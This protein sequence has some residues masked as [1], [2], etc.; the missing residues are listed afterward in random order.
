MC[1]HW[2][3]I[4]LHWRVEFFTASNGTPYYGVEEV[5]LSVDYGV[6]II[7]VIMSKCVVLKCDV[8]PPGG[9]YDLI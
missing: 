8:L 2:C 1:T 4:S 7:V 5:S 9:L 3:T 6:S